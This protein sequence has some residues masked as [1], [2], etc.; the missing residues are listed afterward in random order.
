MNYF[1]IAYHVFVRFSQIRR[2]QQGSLERSFGYN[3]PPPL[4]QTQVPDF[5]FPPPPADL[6]PPSPSPRTT[7]RAIMDKENNLPEKLER[8]A[9]KG[10]FYCLSFILIGSCKFQKC[11]PQH[12]GNCEHLLSNF[13]VKIPSKQR[14][15]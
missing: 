1:K 12:C 4:Q 9:S 6:P 5:E 15:Y 13:L 2:V 8:S 3:Q 10:A 7:R 11:A 14:F